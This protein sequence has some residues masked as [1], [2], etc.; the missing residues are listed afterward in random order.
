MSICLMIIEGLAAESFCP[1][2]PI[3]GLCHGGHFQLVAIH[4]TASPVCQ[5][6]CIWCPQGLL[7]LAHLHCAL[8]CLNSGGH[9]LANDSA[10]ILDQQTLMSINCSALAFLFLFFSPSHNVSY[11]LPT[12]LPKFPD[13]NLDSQSIL[14][15]MWHAPHEQALLSSIKTIVFS[16]ICF[17]LNS[18]T[19]ESQ[20]Q[21]EKDKMSKWFGSFQ[22]L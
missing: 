3:G 15:S 20:F 1:G 19:P 18:C 7:S 10:F 16:K 12:C 4:S 8:C 13:I 14:W 11:H 5:E 21:M 17:F 6:I 22:K 2:L 9:L